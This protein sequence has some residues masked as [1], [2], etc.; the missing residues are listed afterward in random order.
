MT[1]RTSI[2]EVVR[3]LA[4]SDTTYYKWRIEYG[5]LQVNQA[6]RYKELEEENQR[7]RKVIANLKML[8][9]FL[10]SKINGTNMLLLLSISRN[11]CNQ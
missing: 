2:E 1:P 8:Y 4:V 5:G 3:Q 7:L 9:L 6:K 11:N 10:C